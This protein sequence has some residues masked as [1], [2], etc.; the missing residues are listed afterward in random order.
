MTMNDTADSPQYLL[1]ATTTRKAETYVEWNDSNKTMAKIQSILT[2]MAFKKSQ[3]EKE[4]EAA[5]TK[6]LKK[7]SVALRRSFLER[8]HFPMM[9]ARGEFICYY[10]PKETKVFY[11]E[12]QPFAVEKQG[13]NVSSDGNAFCGVVYSCI[14][15]IF[16]DLPLRNII[17]AYMEPKI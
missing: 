3:I 4:M 11:Y 16:N 8:F 14:D 9:L 7:M 17:K 1:A 2:D 12:G 10:G 13:M 6:Y 15:T 5:Q